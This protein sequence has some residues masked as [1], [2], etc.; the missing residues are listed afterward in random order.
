MAKKRTSKNFL[1]ISVT[2]REI[3]VAEFETHKKAWKAMFKEIKECPDWEKE[4]KDIYDEEKDENGYCN[5]DT[6]SI[7]EN[8]AH[9]NADYGDMNCDWM[10]YEKKDNFD[11]IKIAKKLIKDNADNEGMKS[12]D[13]MN[14]NPYACGVHDGI[15]DMVSALGIDIQTSLKTDYYN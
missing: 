6:F 7:N 5:T 12:E 3:T 4:W 8:N 1:L 9:A 11:I 15:L 14:E 13:P 2:E 10:I